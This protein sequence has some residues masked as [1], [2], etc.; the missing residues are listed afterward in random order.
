MK[1]YRVTE[2]F[3]SKIIT[4]IDVSNSF[5][6]DVD[7]DVDGNLLIDAYLKDLLIDA[8]LKQVDNQNEKEYTQE[9]TH[10]GFE[11]EEILWKRK[12]QKRK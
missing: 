8:H 9:W 10:E 3:T 6:L 7:V 5:D 12:Q 1:R 11:F 2:N 4:E